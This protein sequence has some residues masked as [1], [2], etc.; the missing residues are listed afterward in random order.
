VEYQRYAIAADDPGQAL[1][2]LALRLRELG[3][4]VL[5]APALDEAALLTRQESRRVGAVLLPASAL[6]ADATKLPRLFGLPAARLLPVAGAV[7]D[8]SAWAR[9]GARLAI[10]QP[11]GDADLR[12]A[13]QVALAYED[14]GEF[15]VDLRA[16]IDAEAELFEVRPGGDRCAKVRLVDISAGGAYLAL[17]EPMEAGHRAELALPAELSGARVE[18]ECVFPWRRGADTRGTRPSG[19]GV[20]FTQPDLSLRSACRAYVRKQIARFELAKPD[21]A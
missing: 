4:D 16:P 19:M 14:Q 2:P 7:D 18:I 6:G 1:G 9:S 11:C 5:Y 8:L 13:V 21:A 12:F 3:V 17:D 15:R 20:M 10:R